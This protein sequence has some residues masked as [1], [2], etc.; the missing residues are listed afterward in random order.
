MAHVAGRARQG[1]ELVRVWD[2]IRSRLIDP[3]LRAQGTPVSMARGAAL[4]TWL[5][6]TPTVGIQMTIA[7]F[8]GIPWGANLPIAIALIWLSNPLTMLPLYYSFY[9]LGT[10]ILPGPVRSYRDVASQLSSHIDAIVNHGEGV[11]TALRSLGRDIGL[12]MVVG[13]L[14]LATALAIPAYYIT[15]RWATRR[16]ARRLREQAQAHVVEAMDAH[17]S[18]SA[19]PAGLADQTGSRAPGGP[20]RPGVVSPMSKGAPP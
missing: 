3:V 5:T 10:A 6:L 11:L 9:W 2:L 18:A 4:G 8:I 12:P 17:V 7:A 13:S 1:H 20:A 19:S 15:L 16:H 14:V